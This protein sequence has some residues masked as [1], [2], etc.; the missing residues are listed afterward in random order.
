[1]ASLVQ[2]YRTTRGAL[3]SLNPGL[4]LEHLKPGD[5][6]Y[7]MSRPGVFQKVQSGLT[8]SD[9]ARAYQV[10][11]EYLLR[12]NDIADPR[13]LTAGRELFIPDGNPLPRDRM[14]RMMAKRKAREW[15]PRGSVG[16]PLETSGPL[17]VSDGYGKRRHPIT[18][19]I[20]FHPGLDLVAPWGTPV[21]SVKEGTVTH[22]GWK[23]GYGKLVVISH[24]N[25]LVSYY[26][27]L[28]EIF[29]KDGDTVTEG[30]LIGK[31][32]ATGDVTAPHLHFELRQYGSARN[33]S[34]Y[35]T[36]YF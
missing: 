29:V 24:P 23:G 12:V 25:G 9:V 14:T 7:I 5:R 30:Q 21:L 28:T 17:V 35:L 34:R 19:E 31:V 13:K 20:Q 8:I 16:N 22:A 36:R 2:E 33:P 10:N 4:D 32:G 1:M 18:G 26:G 3:E 11:S 15:T 6:V 27:H